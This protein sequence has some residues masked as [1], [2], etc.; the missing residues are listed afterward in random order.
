MD[1]W[2]NG[3]ERGQ[4]RG[5][6]EAGRGEEEDKPVGWAIPF[7]TGCIV[8][9][10]MAFIINMVKVKLHVEAGEFSWLQ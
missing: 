4:H 2:E 7:N 1:V 9:K 5:K 3:W 6:G 10:V 8:L